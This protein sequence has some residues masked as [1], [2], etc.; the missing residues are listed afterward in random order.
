MTLILHLRVGCAFDKFSAVFETTAL[1]KSELAADCKERRLYLNQLKDWLALCERTNDWD[2]V[3]N[4]RLQYK[5][6]NSDGW[7]NELESELNRKE[8]KKKC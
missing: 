8:K 6:R 2:W 7:S 4:K 1:N 3:K 5:T